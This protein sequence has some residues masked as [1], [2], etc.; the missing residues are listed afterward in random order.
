MYKEIMTHNAVVDLPLI[1]LILFCCVFLAVIVRVWL[2]GGADP[3][4]RYME[5]L[6]LEDDVAPGLHT[7][8]S[9]PAPTPTPT[10]SHTFRQTGGPDDGR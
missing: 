7:L 3:E 1:A 4:H 8:T 10:P 2:K 9:P 6:P 5:R